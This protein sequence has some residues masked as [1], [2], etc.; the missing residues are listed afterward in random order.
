V[1]ALGAPSFAHHC[2]SVDSSVGVVGTEACWCACEPQADACYAFYAIDEGMAT[3]WY[4][5]DAH[6]GAATT[7]ARSRS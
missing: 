1:I 6:V 2:I 5:A 7:Q 3:W 4:D